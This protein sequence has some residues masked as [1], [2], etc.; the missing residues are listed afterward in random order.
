MFWL[1]FA[2]ITLVY[3]ALLFRRMRVR[4]REEFDRAFEEAASIHRGDEPFEVTV[5]TQTNLLR[6]GAVVLM[7]PIALV[8]LRLFAARGA[9]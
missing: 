8:V 2:V 4:G 6:A 1:F 5:S 7:M 9:P 3:W